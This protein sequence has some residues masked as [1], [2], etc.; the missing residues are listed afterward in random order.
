M[1]PFLNEGLNYVAGLRPD[2]LIFSDTITLIPGSKQSLLNFYPPGQ[3]VMDVY[4]SGTRVVRAIDRDVLDSANPS[5]HADTPS[6]V[7]TNYV[8]DARDPTTFWVYPPAAAGATI[9]LAYVQQVVPVTSLTLDDD[10]QMAD[11]YMPALISFVLSRLYGRETEADFNAS[12][13]SLYFQQCTEFLVGKTKSDLAA[14]PE[15]NSQGE[16]VPKSAQL[17]GI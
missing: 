3:R 7:I 16:I 9:D 1:L 5:W 4:R 12:L 15:L 14:S 10:L 2:A 17:G 11:T 13:A 6:T 8:Y